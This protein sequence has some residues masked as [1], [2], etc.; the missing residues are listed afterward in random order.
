MYMTASHG[1]TFREEYASAGRERSE[2]DCAPHGGLL[3]R[4]SYAHVCIFTAIITG[5]MGS[6]PVGPVLIW[7]LSITKARQH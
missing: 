6:S 7:R 5:P 3:I 1:L 2:K 4:R